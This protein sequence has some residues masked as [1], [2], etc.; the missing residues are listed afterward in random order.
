MQPQ[1]NSCALLNTLYAFQQRMLIGLGMGYNSAQSP[2][3]LCT[4]LFAHFYAFFAF[5]KNFHLIPRKIRALSADAKLKHRL[6]IF[7]FENFRIQTVTNY[8]FLNEPGMY[9][10]QDSAEMMHP[11]LS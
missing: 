4:I 7:R 6:N 2:Q 3:L 10:N 1:N 11:L 5:H 9:N 8:C